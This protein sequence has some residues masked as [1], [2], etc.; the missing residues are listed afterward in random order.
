MFVANHKNWMNTLGPWPCL[1]KSGY[2]HH[3]SFKSPAPAGR[4]MAVKHRMGLSRTVGQDPAIYWLCESRV[5]LDLMFNHQYQCLFR[6]APFSD[7]QIIPIRQPEIGWLFHLLI[8]IQG[9]A[10]W[11]RRNFVRKIPMPMIRETQIMVVSTSRGANVEQW[12]NMEK[13][14]AHVDNCF[15]QLPCCIVCVKL[16]LPM[17]HLPKKRLESYTQDGIS[18]VS[19]GR[20]D[21]QVCGHIL[22]SKTKNTMDQRSGLQTIAWIRTHI[23]CQLCCQNPPPLTTPAHWD[24]RPLSLLPF[25]P[26]EL[27]KNT[28]QRAAEFPKAKSDSVIPVGPGPHRSGNFEKKRYRTKMAHRK[29]PETQKQVRCTN[30][31]ANCC[32]DATTKDM[33][34]RTTNWMNHEPT[35][36]WN[37]ES[38]TP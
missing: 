38:M 20:H 1:T 25:Q 15:R 18:R 14:H 29:A 17:F 5:P 11:G 22:K 31:W 7:T 28:P 27:G 35:N 36:R 24:Q 13:Q 33:N 8:V 34:P 10:W 37:N 9:T 26:L 3:Q 4:K 30:A 6:G 12:K 23:P 19:F 21:W 16:T 2:S 32:R